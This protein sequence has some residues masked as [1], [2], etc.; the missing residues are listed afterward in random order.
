MSPADDRT[1]TMAGDALIE[2]PTHSAMDA[3][4][5]AASPDDIWPRLPQIGY[6]RGG[7]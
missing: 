2:N 7:L 6:Q 3:I 1:R 5:I 4:T